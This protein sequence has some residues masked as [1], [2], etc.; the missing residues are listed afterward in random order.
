MPET[1]PL[2]VF[3]HDP[4]VPIYIG[5][6]STVHVVNPPQ[7]K[8]ETKEN[9]IVFTS[10]TLL[11]KITSGIQESNLR[12]HLKVLLVREDIEAKLLSHILMNAKMR[13]LRILFVYNNPDEVRRMYDAWRYGNTDKLIA[14]AWISEDML[15]IVD[16]RLNIIRVSFNEI[17]A[18]GKIR[19]NHR[20]DFRISREGSFINWPDEDIHLDIDAIR[21]YTDPMWRESRDRDKLIRNK[22]F[23]AAIASLRNK[24]GR[25]QSDISGLSSRQVRRI[26]H[27]HGATSSALALL[28]QSHQMNLT[29]YLNTVAEEIAVL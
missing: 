2:T 9:F 17:P 23:G 13:S 8:W 19:K 4:N 24:E 22:K 27:G 26:E 28:A 16:C 21:Y 14:R 18:L 11:P 15:F 3:K 20:H 7:F 12:H 5:N 10:A 25:R 6:S 29:S 1:R